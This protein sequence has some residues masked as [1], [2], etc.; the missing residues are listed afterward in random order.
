MPYTHEVFKVKSS[1]QLD[2]TRL[3]KVKYDTDLK[4]FS[5]K[6]G[7]FRSYSFTLSVSNIWLSANWK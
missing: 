6:D 1:K 7:Y 2:I 5:D 4:R 3:S